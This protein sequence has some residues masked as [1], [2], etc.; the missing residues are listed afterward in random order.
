MVTKRNGE[1]VVVAD[2]RTLRDALDAPARARVEAEAREREGE[3]RTRQDGLLTYA[4]KIAEKLETAVAA[5]AAWAAAP[6]DMA[7]LLRTFGELVPVWRASDAVNSGSH[8]I[9]DAARQSGEVAR[10]VKELERPGVLPAV[11]LEAILRVL[12]RAAGHAEGFPAVYAAWTRARQDGVALL[13]AIRDLLDALERRWTTSAEENAL[14]AR[15]QQR[16]ADAA[17]ATRPYAPPPP[18]RGIPGAQLDATSA[19]PLTTRRPLLENMEDLG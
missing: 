9:V 6:V 8:P 11:R 18:P 13:P 1:P 15:H 5:S 2:L 3:Q 14:L 10:L 12:E 4:R 17:A 19:A 16:L 7:A